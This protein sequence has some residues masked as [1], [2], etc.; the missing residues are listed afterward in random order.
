[1]TASL[2]AKKNVQKL[3]E[4]ESY[5]LFMVGVREYL[6]PCSDALGRVETVLSA[7]GLVNASR[8]QRFQAYHLRLLR[9]FTDAVRFSGTSSDHSDQQLPVADAH[10][11]VPSRGSQL[12]PT[13]HRQNLQRHEEGY[14]QSL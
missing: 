7:V 8:S 13:S 11:Q 9:E 14:R 3:H 6:I 2:S 12:Y 10:L 5:R 1:M 4:V